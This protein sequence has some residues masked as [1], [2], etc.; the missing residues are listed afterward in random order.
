[1]KFHDPGISIY[2]FKV[3]RS[4]R[5]SLV[6]VI[7]ERLEELEDRIEELEEA[8]GLDD[9]SD[10]EGNVGS[11]NV[12]VPGNVGV[13]SSA[14]PPTTETQSLCPPADA[15]GNVG[16]GNVGNVGNVGVGT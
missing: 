16:D 15:D 3:R 2:M 9:M 11:G 1:M 6:S 13:G 8:V 7:K 5:R 10:D 12:N 4:R 14:P